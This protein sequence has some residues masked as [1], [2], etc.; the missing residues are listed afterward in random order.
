[1][2][3]RIQKGFTL[4][5]LLVVIT[6]IALLA[7]LA[8]PVYTTVQEKGNITKGINNCRQ[9][10]TSLKVWAADNG[11]R[12][13]DSW[14]DS[15]T[16]GGGGG[17]G[18]GGDS[19]GNISDS[20]AAFKVLFKEGIIAD[21]RIFG[22]PASPYN[23][24]GNVGKAPE[25]SDA[26]K[27]GEN[28]WSMTKGLNDSSP[29][30]YPIVFENAK[31]QGWD[32]TWDTKAVGSSKKGRVWSGPN[33]IIGLNDGSVQKMKID[34]QSGKLKNI[35]A[36]TNQFTVNPDKPDVLAPMGGQ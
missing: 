18:A 24:D 12:Y 14:T 23:P 16:T 26:L 7:S 27:T 19:G 33:I 22:C 2:K 4:I 28:H 5:E 11:G 8:M 6:I 20:N 15:A 9:I 31:D 32:P 3:K 1:M 30:S 25:Y 36:E 21:E 17:G 13:P 34:P 10:I 29:A 35:G